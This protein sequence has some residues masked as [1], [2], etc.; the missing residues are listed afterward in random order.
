ML[1]CECIHWARTAG[2]FTEHHPHCPKYDPEG[3]AIKIIKALLRGIEAW[4]ADEDGVH[5]ECWE[6]YKKAQL[7]VGE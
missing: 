5:P 6:A 3:D 1:D 7:C 4:A 2:W